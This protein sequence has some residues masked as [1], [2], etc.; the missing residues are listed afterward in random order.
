M[1]AKTVYILF[2][3]TIIILISGC[4]VMPRLSD[5]TVIKIVTGSGPE[6]LVLDTSAGYPRLLVSCNA[7]RPEQPYMGEIYEV[8]IKTDQSFPLKRTGEPD[9]LIFNPHG[10]SITECD[11]GTFLYVISHNDAKKRHYIVKY[12]VLHG[13]LKFIAIFTHSLLVSP[14]A[15]TAN[16][17]GSFWISND[18]GKRGSKME[19]LFKLKR[20]KVIYFDGKGNWTVAAERLAFGNGI[21]TKGDT[22]YL[23]TTRQNKLFSYTIQPD[24]KLINRKTIA[25]ITGQDN[26]RFDSN[27]LLVAVHLKPF[28]FIRHI[29]DPLKKSPTVIYRINLSD[30]KKEAIYS[31]DGSG[32]SA[33][34]TGLIYNGYLYIAQVFDS[35]ILKVRLPAD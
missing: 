20:S 30:L 4:T 3:F 6:D 19:M 2:T 29:K 7:R 17:D 9:S 27:S 23:A 35:F 25:K 28:A 10:I 32:I 21:V 26:L 5:Y 31:D 34:S 1:K 13:E 18:A 12:K 33:G 15:L 16:S 11:A 14:N 24:G 22:A 8:N